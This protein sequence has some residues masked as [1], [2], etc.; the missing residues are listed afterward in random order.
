VDLTIVRNIRKGLECL[1]F[2]WGIESTK[3]FPSDFVG[4]QKHGG[5]GGRSSHISSTYYD[6]RQMS[7]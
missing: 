3:G 7:I 1:N 5:E 2:D 4:V 6:R